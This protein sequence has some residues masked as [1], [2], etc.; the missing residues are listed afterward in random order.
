MVSRPVRRDP[1]LYMGLG[2]VTERWLSGRQERRR[3][4]WTDR[5]AGPVRRTE[6][7]ARRISAP[8]L[9]E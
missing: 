9:R 7:K 2:K 8:L 4:D 1:L 5:E 6:G 3:R